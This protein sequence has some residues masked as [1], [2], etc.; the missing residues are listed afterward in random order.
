MPEIFAATPFAPDRNFG[1]AC[2]RFLSLLP[3]GSWAAIMD[4]DAMFTSSHWHA[5]MLEAIACRPDAGAFAVV[6]NRIASPWQKALEAVNAG[7][8]IP[9]HRAIG[10]ARRRTHRTLLDISCTKGFG[11]VVTLVNRDA[12]AETAGYAD[13]LFCVDHS[14][15]FRLVDRGRRVYLI[16][17]LY[18]YHLRATSSQRGV[19]QVPKWEACPCRGAETQPTERIQ[20]P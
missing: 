20:L 1:A 14:L 13:G 6:T 8:D 17:G 3:A 4:H 16:E 10:E 2:N 5:Q 11:G 15:H 7:D 18:V 12:W 19:P 9:K